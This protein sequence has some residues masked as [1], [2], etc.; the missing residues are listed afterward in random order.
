MARIFVV[1]VG[2]DTKHSPVR[3]PVF[4]DGRFELVPIVEFDKRLDRFPIVHKKPLQRYCDIACFNYDAG[5]N[6]GVYAGRKAKDVAHNDPEFEEM[7]Y[8]DLSNA[9]ASNLIGSARRAER[10]TEKGDYLFFLARLEEYDGIR[11][12]GRAGHYF[13]GYFQVEACFGPK[14]EPL[15]DLEEAVIGRNA[16]V[17]R[18]K[19]DPELWS[20][21]ERR[22][23]VFKGGPGSVRFMTGLEATWGWMCSVFRDVDGRPWRT[24]EGKSVE[25]RIASYT[26]TIRCHLDPCN[27]DQID[28]YDRFW[29]RV[30]D[31]LRRDT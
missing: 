10:G 11:Y 14:Q 3:S 6:L 27:A 25:Q 21:P 29:E 12:T 30:H 5:A 31:H 23:W 26:R 24:M 22:F 20:D 15:S 4:R 28:R 8:G 1:R 2:A 19:A 9:K 13:V 7:T 18:A 16:H 17:R